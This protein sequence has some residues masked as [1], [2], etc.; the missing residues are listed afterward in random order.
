[1]IDAVLSYHMNPATCGVAKFNHRLARE[2]GVPMAPLSQLPAFHYPLVSLKSA[3]GYSIWPGNGISIHQAFD[4][5]AHDRPQL[6]ATA[7]DAGW[8][9]RARRIYAANA[10]IAAAIRSVRPD[11][12]DAWCPSLIEGNASRAALNVLTFGM[13]HK[14]QLANYRTLK[15]R[16]DETGDTYT[17]S[18]STAV[19]EGSPWDAVARVG[20]ELRA[21]FGDTLRQ[22]GFLADDALARELTECSLVALFFDP[23]LR[24]N[25]TSFWSAL[26]AGKPIV[27]NLDAH[28]PVLPGASCVQDIRS[29]GPWWLRG[30]CQRWACMGDWSRSRW[31]GLARSRWP[32]LV[33]LF[34]HA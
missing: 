25:N 12:I 30:E 8:V 5:F 21:I 27:T 20:D 16:L 19:H 9:R 14:L 11:V 32:G 1:M 29:I 33:G 31:P 26:E 24:A 4:F 2:L 34:T 15:Q 3:E 6:S 7:L 10:E 17:V 28:S 23:A 22:L 18:L 13:A